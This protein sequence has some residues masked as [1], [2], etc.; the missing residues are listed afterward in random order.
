MNRTLFIPAAAALLFFSAASVNS[1][2]PQAPS[3]GTLL[4]QL[5]A[6]QA[7]NKALIEKQ[8]KTLQTLDDIK[9][10]ADQLK[11]LGKRG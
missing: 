5:Q 2:A 7:A 10:A 1:Q 6:I 4:S 9:A 3:S 8:Q 11:V